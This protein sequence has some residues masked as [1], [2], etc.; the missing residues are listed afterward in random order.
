MPQK[1]LATSL[2]VL[3][4]T[5]RDQFSLLWKWEARFRGVQFQGRVMLRGRPLI[6][7]VKGS[8]II[9]GDGVQI[10]SSFRANPLGC[11]Q[12]SV[13]RA[14]APGA[15]VI[16]GPNVGL[17]GAVLN[18][19]KRIEVGEGTIF[20]SGA[21]VF[22]N[23]FHMPQG[24]WGWGTDFQSSAQPVTIGRGVFVGARAIIMKGV[25]IGDRAVV[26]AGAVVTKDVPAG[27]RAVGNPAR[28]L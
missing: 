1:T 3:I 18:A 13:V 24:E 14:L 16:L 19:G 28:V 7:M 5:V 23:D 15:E 4:G 8:R 11:F 2:G 20:G 25:T 12:P 9:I 6:T 22:D 17:S 27:Q 26:G 21:M 10:N